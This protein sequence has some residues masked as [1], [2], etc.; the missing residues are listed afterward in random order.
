M[1]AIQPFSEDE[2][3]AAFRVFLPDARAREV[4]EELL[5][6]AS[7]EEGF[8]RWRPADFISFDRDVLILLSIQSE[9]TNAKVERYRR[10]GGYEPTAEDQADWESRRAELRAAVEQSMTYRRQHPGE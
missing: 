9:E 2:L 10:L 7:H 3:L 8:G 6:S 1:S 4:V 5:T